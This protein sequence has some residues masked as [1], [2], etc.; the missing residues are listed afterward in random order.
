MNI[1]KIFFSDFHSCDKKTET[2]IFINQLYKSTE[3]QL[4]SSTRIGKIQRCGISPP[5]PTDI[6]V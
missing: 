6:R 1:T 3:Y 2:S 5:T 4:S